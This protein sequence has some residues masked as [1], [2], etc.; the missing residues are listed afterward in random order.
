MVYGGNAVETTDREDHIVNDFYGKVAPRV[1]HVR[2]WRPR[3]GHWVVDFAAAH[4]R[5]AIETTDDVDLWEKK[6]L[7]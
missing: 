4:S 1:V 3:V 2:Y 7:D 5:D 6:I